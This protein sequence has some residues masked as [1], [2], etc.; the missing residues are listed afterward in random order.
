[1]NLSAPEISLVVV[2]W[3]STAFLRGCLASVHRQ[4]RRISLEIIVVDSGSYDGCGDM[5]VAEFPEAKFLQLSE[6][7]GFGRANDIGVGQA[8]GEFVWFLNP[9]TELVCDAAA[10]LREVFHLRPATGIAGARLLNADRSIQTTCVHPLPTPLNQALDSEFLRRRLGIWG[11]R[12]FNERAVPVKVE[13]VSGACMM[14]RR[15]D[16]LRAGGF[17]SR[18]FMYGEDMDLC[19]RIRGLGREILHVPTAEV[20]HYEG[21]SSRGQ[22]KKFSVVMMRQSLDSYFKANHGLTQAWLHRWLMALSAVAR[23]ALLAIS[24]LFAGRENGSRSFRKWHAIL[25]WCFG[26][27]R[28]TK[29][30][31]PQ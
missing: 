19:F 3:N 7:V 23:I 16:F 4:C 20:I 9:D 21:G 10:I 12:A 24:S 18:F 17:G 27:E 14:L 30:F 31:P 15:G 29:S 6:N 28:W 13:A 2:N 5:L 22:F 11:V 8:H 1:M 25:S 26:L